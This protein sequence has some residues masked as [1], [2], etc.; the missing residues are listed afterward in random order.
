MVKRSGFS[1][2]GAKHFNSKSMTGPS[3]NGMS[4]MGGRGRMPHY[5]LGGMAGTN[6]NDPGQGNFGGTGVKTG[7]TTGSSASSGGKGRVGPT[8]APPPKTVKPKAPP[9]AKKPSAPSGPK[10]ALSY[11]TEVLGGR[12]VLGYGGPAPRVTGG[13]GVQAYKRGGSVKKGK[14]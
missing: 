12:G 3:G 8:S 10:P 7:T 4:G 5:A 11:N 2:P 6:T 9:K 14:C 1:M 13:G